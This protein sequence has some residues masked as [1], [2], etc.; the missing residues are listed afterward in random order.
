MTSV[1]TIKAPKAFAALQ[2]GLLSPLNSLY[3]L[4]PAKGLLE[5]AKARDVFTGLRDHSEA[6]DLQFCFDNNSALHARSRCSHFFFF[7]ESNKSTRGKSTTETVGEFGGEREDFSLQPSLWI[8][9][10]ILQFKQARNT[11]L[12]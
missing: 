8:C 6:S 10:E 1:V 2:S 3:S 9:S 7:H 4:S 5:T 11:V 12:G